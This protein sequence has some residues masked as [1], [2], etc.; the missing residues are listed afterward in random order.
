[1]PPHPS[2]TGPPGTGLARK[3]QAALILK[4]VV[5]IVLDEGPVEVEP[6]TWYRESG[7]HYLEARRRDSGEHMR[8]RVDQIRDVVAY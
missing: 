7:T 5:R 1:M 2:P 4:G 6:R 8:V 3:L